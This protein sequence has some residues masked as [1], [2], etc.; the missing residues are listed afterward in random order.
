MEKR[1]AG[2]RVERRL[3]T[4]QSGWQRGKPQVGVGE[5]IHVL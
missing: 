3:V 2:Y 5:I 1:L 4:D